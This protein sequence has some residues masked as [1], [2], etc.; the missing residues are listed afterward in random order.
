MSLQRLSRGGYRLPRI[1]GVS[2]VERSRCAVATSPV[3]TAW[4]LFP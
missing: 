2:L 3:G 1:G 4:N